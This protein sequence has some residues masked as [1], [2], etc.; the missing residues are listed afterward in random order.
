MLSVPKKANDAMHVS[1][2]EGSC[3]PSLSGDASPIP[4][5]RELAQWEGSG[6]K[7]KPGKPGRKKKQQILR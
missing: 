1:M 3:L 6:M 2:L 7:S 5:T 4:K